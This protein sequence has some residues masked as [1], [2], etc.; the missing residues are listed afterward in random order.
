MSSKRILACLAVIILLLFGILFLREKYSSRVVRIGVVLPLS[1]SMSEYGENG[2]DG[3]TLAAAELSS[4]KDM[5]KFELVYEDSREAPQD[6]VAA[7]RRLIDVEHVTFIIGGLTSSGVLAAAPYAQQ[8]GVLFFTPAA[9]APGIPQIGDLVF[10]NWPGDDLIARKFGEVA[11]QKLGARN[12]AILY[13]SNDYGNTNSTYFGKSFSKAGGTVL[14]S[15]AF[16]QGNT[17]F[18]ALITQLSALDHVD[19]ILVIAYPDEYRGFFQGIAA[20]RVSKASILASDTFYSPQLVSELGSGAEGT[21]CAVAA[22]P[23]DE[24][25][26]RRQFIEAYRSRFKTGGGKPK[27]PGLVSDTAYDALRLLVTGISK[28]DGSPKSVARWLHTLNGYPGAAGPTTF[29]ESGDVTG[30]LAIYQVTDGK[31]IRRSF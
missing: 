17:D 25:A 23:G 4:Q 20:S 18:K 3:L 12:I 28:T 5:P 1:G 31:F 8:Q 19:K 7:V 24:Y 2:R 15:R 13:V 26:P 11:Y 29:D 27:D 9:S 6:T 21:V 30:D 14:L 22:K 10:R 16:P